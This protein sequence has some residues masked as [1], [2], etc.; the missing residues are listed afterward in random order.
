MEN[1]NEDEPK[2]DDRIKSCNGG[3][4]DEFGGIYRYNGIASS[5]S[6]IPFSFDN[7]WPGV[8]T[9]E[10]IALPLFDTKGRAMWN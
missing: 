8:E 10:N 4:N 5:Q 6:E 9:K 7:C 1:C 2:S 3:K